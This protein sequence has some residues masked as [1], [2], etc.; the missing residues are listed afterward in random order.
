LFLNNCLA[1]GDANLA[2][3][4]KE[5]SAD[6]IVLVFDNEPRN[7]EIVNMM[8]QAIKQDHIIVI[9][10]SDIE[11]KD[12]N[13]MV[14]NGISPDEIQ[15]IISSNSFNGLRAQLKFNMWKKI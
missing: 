15:E 6:E 1:S 7:K 14:M 12:I 2:L 8:Q 10:P 9:W 4:S 13:E 3:T 5:V 11:G